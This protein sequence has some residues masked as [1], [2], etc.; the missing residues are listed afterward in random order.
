MV[1]H[2]MD[3]KTFEKI[4]ENLFDNL[5]RSENNEGKVSAIKKALLH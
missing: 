2:M 5:V 4:I 3:L 1:V